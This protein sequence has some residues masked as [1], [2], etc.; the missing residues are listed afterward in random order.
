MWTCTEDEIKL[1]KRTTKK[2]SRLLKSMSE[3]RARG[4]LPNENFHIF[5]NPFFTIN[6]PAKKQFSVCDI[7]FVLVVWFRFCVKFILLEFY[8]PQFSSSLAPFRLFICQSANLI[9]CQWILL[10]FVW[11]VCWLSWRSE[12]ESEQYRTRTNKRNVEYENQIKSKIDKQLWNS[13]DIW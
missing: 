2:T 5:E 4:Q 3:T 13:L 11:Q 7:H 12:R 10:T 9:L 8:F 6:R 1:L